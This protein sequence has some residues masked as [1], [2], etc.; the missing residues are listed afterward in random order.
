LLE[1]GNKVKV[2]IMFRGREMAYAVMGQK[3]LERFAQDLADIAFIEKP[4]KV[5][6][7]NMTIIVTPKSN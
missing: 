1:E 2:T 3:L 5:E 7:K 6:G 4:S